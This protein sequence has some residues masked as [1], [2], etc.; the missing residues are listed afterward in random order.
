MKFPKI[1]C[2]GALLGRGRGDKHAR[3]SASKNTNC[4]SNLGNRE[5]ILR[6]AQC[7]VTGRNPLEFINLT[8]SLYIGARSILSEQGAAKTGALFEDLQVRLTVPSVNRLQSLSGLFSGFVTEYYEE[9]A[10]HGMHRHATTKSA[11][12]IE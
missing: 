9:I 11:N 2:E 12:D 8:A 7:A 10:S 6:L 5:Y 1:S 3:R 4:A